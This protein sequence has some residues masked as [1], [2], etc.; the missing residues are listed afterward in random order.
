[1]ASSKIDLDGSI[2]QIAMLDESDQ[3][4]DEKNCDQCTVI[5]EHLVMQVFQ[6]LG[7]SDRTLLAIENDLRDQQ[8]RTKAALE[9]KQVVTEPKA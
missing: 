7:L 1:M 6:S 4:K 8:S 2:E 3:N 9:L 5:R